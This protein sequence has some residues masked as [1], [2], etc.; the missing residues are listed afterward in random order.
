MEGKVLASKEV[1]TPKSRIRKLN[2]VGVFLKERKRSVDVEKHILTLHS[3]YH[4]E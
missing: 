1:E 3:L 2:A 4:K